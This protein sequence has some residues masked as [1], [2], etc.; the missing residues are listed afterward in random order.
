VAA[1]GNLTLEFETLPL[2]VFAHLVSRF[3]IFLG[4]YRGKLSRLCRV[5]SRNETITDGY[6]SWIS[7]PFLKVYVWPK[8]CQELHTVKKGSL[9]LI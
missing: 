9:C 4:P 6:N 7:R 1:G 8:L 3:F 2:K 5:E